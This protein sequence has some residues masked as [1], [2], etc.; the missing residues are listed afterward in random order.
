MSGGIFPG[1]P[2]AWNVKC[3]IFT[4]IVA[5]GYWS[6]PSKNKYVLTFLLWLPYV[7]LAWYDYMYA[8]QDKMHPTII[9]F[10]RKFFLPFKPPDYKL[11]FDQL[12]KEQIKSMDKLD[13]IVTWSIAVAAMY[14]FVTKKWTYHK[15]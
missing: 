11:E 3:I 10:G 15:K 9:P 7:S 1:R 2:F 13:H 5:G 12:P 14:M 8:C 6:L 4:A